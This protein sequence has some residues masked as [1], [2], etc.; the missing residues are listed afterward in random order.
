MLLEWAYTFPKF[1]GLGIMSHAMAQLAALAGKAGARWALT[2]VEQSNVASLK[3][4]KNA[5]FRP[6]QLREERWRALRPVQTYK[7]LPTDSKYSFES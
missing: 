5:G 3:G 1:R 4:C 6:Y 7:L 2:I